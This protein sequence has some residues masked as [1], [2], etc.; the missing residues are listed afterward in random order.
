MLAIE[1]DRVI[2]PFDI[3]PARPGVAF[4]GRNV[5]FAYWRIVRK[6][7]EV[8]T[9]KISNIGAEV[10]G[11]GR[12]FE[13]S[14]AIMTQDLGR[15]T[16]KN[17][18]RASDEG[19]GIEASPLL[20]R[21]RVSTIGRDPDAVRRGHDPMILIEKIDIG[22]HLREQVRGCSPL[23]G[24]AHVGRAQELGGTRPKYPL[25][26]D[27]GPSDI[28]VRAQAPGRDQLPLCCSG[29]GGKYRKDGDERGPG[30]CSHGTLVG[31]GRHLSLV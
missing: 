13:R 9:S 4:V 31:Y 28:R 11:D 18:F 24:L 25:G 1:L 27:Q 17:V 15:S 3:P 14:P 7:Y 10:A 6:C 26:M 19:R 21:P 8:I 20:E 23:P 12:K 29:Y 30:D 16:G 22:D 5:D 2:I